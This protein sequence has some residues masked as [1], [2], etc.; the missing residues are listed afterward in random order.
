MIRFTWNMMIS[1]FGTRHRKLKIFTF[2]LVISWM[3]FMVFTASPF[4]IG[5]IIIYMPIIGKVY[6]KPNF[7][8][9]FYIIPRGKGLIARYL[10]IRST[11]YSI[12]IAL[13]SVFIKLIFNYFHIELEYELTGWIITLLMIQVVLAY[14]GSYSR[15]G[16]IKNKIYLGVFWALFV[17]ILILDISIIG[18]GRFFTA[19]TGIYIG[20]I[21]LLISEM[22]SIAVYNKVELEEYFVLERT[23]K[24]SFRDT[25]G[26]KEK[27]GDK[28]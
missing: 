16:K 27:A 26:E 14:H 11:I 28:N 7:N 8:K 3:L 19:K 2:I 4:V 24:N 15:L 21:S 13:I 23:F 1:D 18:V 6:F 17:L 10:F 20:I 9:I 12:I 25:F 5:A 22:L